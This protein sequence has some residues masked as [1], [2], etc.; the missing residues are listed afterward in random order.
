MQRCYLIGSLVVCLAGLLLYLGYRVETLLMFNW[1]ENMGGES[2][3]RWIRGFLDAYPLARWQWLIFSLPFSLWILSYLLFITALWGK[4][5]GREFYLYFFL[6]PCAS[7][8]IET[9]QLT[10]WVPGHFDWVDVFF[11]LAATGV[12]CLFLSLHAKGKSNE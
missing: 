11:I 12:G 7:L 8:V 1:L 10:R 6:V 4:D 9:M 2:T 3:V 5:K